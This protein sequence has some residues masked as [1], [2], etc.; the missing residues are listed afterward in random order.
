MEIK[1]PYRAVS[2]QIFAAHEKAHHSVILAADG[3][4]RACT[5]ASNIDAA[6]IKT[7]Q[8]IEVVNNNAK[9]SED[10]DATNGAGL[11]ESLCQRR[12]GLAHLFSYRLG[13]LAALNGASST[14]T[15]RNRSR[16][17]GLKRLFM[18]KMQS[19]GHSI[20]YCGNGHRSGDGRGGGSR[21]PTFLWSS[22]RKESE[23]K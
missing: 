8:D 1:P 23:S 14:L 6:A 13:G 10:G 5:S 16:W 7:K 12:Q 19:K 4:G 11:C 15:S 18:K 22:S 3:L 2:P 9:Q 21:V 17:A 20:T